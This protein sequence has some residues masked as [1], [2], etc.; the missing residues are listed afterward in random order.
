MQC[1]KRRRA[2]CAC[3]AV[4]CSVLQCISGCVKELQVALLSIAAQHEGGDHAAGCGRASLLYIYARTPHSVPDTLPIS[5]NLS[6][7]I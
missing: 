2:P 5:C 1:G 6:L 7:H 4:Q 3:Q